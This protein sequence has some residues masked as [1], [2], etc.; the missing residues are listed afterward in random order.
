MRSGAF[1][2]STRP[3]LLALL[4]ALAAWPAAAQTVTR[5]AAPG[6]PA[7]A[8]PG[9][10]PAAPVVGT[11]RLTAVAGRPMPLHTGDFVTCREDVLSGAVQ[12]FGDGSYV[13]KTLTRQ[14]CRAEEDIRYNEIS[15]GHW[16]Q[17]GGRV[18]LDGTVPGP[19]PADLEAR[20]Y[21]TGIPLEAGGIAG[22]VEPSALK[23]G[24][25]EGRRLLATLP[26]GEAVFESTDPGPQADLKDAAA[27]PG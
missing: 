26:Q 13:L 9:Q 15:W 22:R 19:M 10:A 16:R 14:S 23:G 1:L 6:Q 17:E 8:A 11:Y 2:P 12:L 3:P 24:R 27:A 20:G 25:V 18:V 5:T 7:A 4:A 21:W